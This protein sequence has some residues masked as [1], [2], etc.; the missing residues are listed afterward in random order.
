MRRGMGLFLAGI[1]AVCLAACGGSD[2]GNGGALMENQETAAPSETE[3]TAPAGRET[4]SMEGNGAANAA[5]S[6]AKR[7]TAVLTVETDQ[8]VCEISPWLY[9]QFIEHI[10][11]CI[12]NGIW[13]EMILDRKFYYEVGDAGL[14]PWKAVGEGTVSMEKSI[15]CGDGMAARLEPGGGVSQQGITLEARG[16]DGSLWAA[17]PGGG[18]S[19]LR[20]ILRT[21]Y[22]GRCE[23][24]LTVS[25]EELR[26]YEFAFDFAEAS[27][28][29]YFEVFSEGGTCVID[30][31]SLMPDDNIGGMRADT[32]AQLKRL[33]ASFYRWPGGNFVSGYDWKDGVGDRDWRASGRNLHYMGQESD[34]ASQD[35][36]LASDREKLKHLGFYGGIEPNDFGLDEFMSMCAY[37]ESEPMVV[38]NS[39]LGS[40]ADAADEVEY[41]NGAADTVWGAKRKDN[42]RAEP[43]G[44][45]LFGVGN[46]MFGDWQL[47]HAEI[48]D[49]APRHAEFA[50]AML[51]RDDSITLI[52]VG[53]NVVSWTGDLLGYCPEYV[54][55]VDEHMYSR[56]FEENIEKHVADVERNLS[57]RILKH[58]MITAAND[59]AKDVGM[60]LLEY[61]YD[62][63]FCPSRLKDALGI[64]VFM[65]VMISNADV[66]KGAAYSSTVNATQGCVTTT[67]T[68]A[69]MQGAGYTL[70]MYRQLMGTVSL[71]CSAEY[72]GYLSVSAASDP[73]TG[74]ITIAVVNPHPDELTIVCDAL[75][76]REVISVRSIVADDPEDYN[77]EREQPIHE[78]ETAGEWK[79]PGYSVS[80]LTVE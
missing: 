75:K 63:V 73:Q 20:V 61:A 47:G 21:V 78:V 30:S 67:N 69:V 22:G 59:K 80:I 29:G 46:E 79:T 16:Y 33:N 9:G 36:M 45:K 53:D 11:T 26:R 35:E 37:L 34:F 72:D 57:E 5:E 18:E 19:T 24:E 50:R 12:Y 44:V 51:E 8:P 27:G 58:R 3:K 13:S 55:Y 14:S 60:M 49:Y 48:A 41:L 6:A 10:E 39:G 64:G 56:R 4:E 71:P 7:N 62:K 43:Y 65:N 32:L 77:T 68:D 74:R 40:A 28:N 2:S 54:D 66:V 42:G 25:G 23:A 31:L 76:D 1:T 70:S 52:G 17:C 38:V 15:T